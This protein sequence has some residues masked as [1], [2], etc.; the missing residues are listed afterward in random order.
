MK[1][2]LGV[3]PLPEGYRPLVLAG[4]EAKPKMRARCHDCAFDPGGSPE[5]SDH[6]AWGA[7]LSGVDKG[8]PFYCHQGMPVDED[9]AYR[10]PVGLD[11]APVGD[12]RICAGWIEMRARFLAVRRADLFD[13]LRGLPGEYPALF[14]IVRMAVTRSFQP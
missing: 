11:G 10:P 5:Q 2:N 7:I 3:Q 4:I 9:G 8:R 12:E 14:G 1:R 6:G 13:D